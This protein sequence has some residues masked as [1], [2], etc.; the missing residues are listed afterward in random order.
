[1]PLTWETVK[2][3]KVNTIWMTI[4]FWTKCFF[5]QVNNLDFWLKGKKKLVKRKLLKW[6]NSNGQNSTIIS[7][8]FSDIKYQCRGVI[9]ANRVNFPW[10]FDGFWWHKLG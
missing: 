4:F 1:M 3:F 9:I 6:R 7:S 2:C 5:S 10:E 8:L